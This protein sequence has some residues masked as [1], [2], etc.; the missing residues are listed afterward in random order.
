MRSRPIR[1]GRWSASV[2]YSIA[3]EATLLPTRRQSNPRAATLHCKVI[4]GTRF[5]TRC[6]DGAAFWAGDNGGL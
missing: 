2:G 1:Y 3:D 5:F 6:W 4:L